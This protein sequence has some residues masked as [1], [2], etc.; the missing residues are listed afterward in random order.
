MMILGHQSVLNILRGEHIEVPFLPGAGQFD[1]ADLVV[2]VLD[3]VE[4]ILEGD[5]EVG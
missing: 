1:R 4:D 2:S 5:V 3:E